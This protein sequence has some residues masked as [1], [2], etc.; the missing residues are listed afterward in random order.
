MSRKNEQAF[1]FL[2]KHIFINYGYQ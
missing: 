2:D 1:V